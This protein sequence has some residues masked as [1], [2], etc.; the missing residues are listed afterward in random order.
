MYNSIVSDNK[1]YM[2]KTVDLQ[3]YIALA[4]YAHTS[5]CTTCR[6]HSHSTVS[7]FLRFYNFPRHRLD[8]E[9]WLDWRDCSMVFDILFSGMRLLGCL[10]NLQICKT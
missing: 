5:I 8:S 4:A 9:S 7:L 2:W 1:F 6:P 10:W 3:L